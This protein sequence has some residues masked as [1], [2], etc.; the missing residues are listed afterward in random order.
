MASNPL[1]GRETH[2]VWRGVG[3]LHLDAEKFYRPGAVLPRDLGRHVFDVAPHAIE[4]RDGYSIAAEPVALQE[5]HYVWNGGPR[6]VGVLHAAKG[7]VYHPGDVLP[8]EI[9]ER[10]HSLFPA[11]VEV[12]AGHAE[13]AEAKEP[14]VE[15]KRPID[16]NPER[17][18]SDEM[19][20]AIDRFFERRMVEETSKAVKQAREA[21]PS[22]V[23]DRQVEEDKEKANRY[24]RTRKSAK[25]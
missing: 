14:L 24:R 19:K 16:I 25:S 2:Y 10:N 15:Y 17:V 4:I 21:G 5:R 3:M 23:A 22:V 12:Q 11:S 8:V 6:G 20:V 7:V 13:P 1:T 18:L 9:G